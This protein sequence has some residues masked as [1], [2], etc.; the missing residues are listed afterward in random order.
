MAAGSGLSQKSVSNLASM[1]ARSPKKGTTI[2][3]LQAFAD[4]MG[5]PAYQLLI[6][7]L[8]EGGDRRAQLDRLIRAFVGA[9]PKQQDWLID[10]LEMMA[11]IGPESRK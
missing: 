8:P 7:N 9:T 1:G 11:H 2:G 4:H 5:M 6:E 10:T 3:T